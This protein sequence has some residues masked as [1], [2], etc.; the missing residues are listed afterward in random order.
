MAKTDGP[1]TARTR[2]AGGMKKL[3][4]VGIVAGVALGLSACA[5]Q[6]TAVGSWGNAE[7]RTEPSLVLSED[8]RLTG[9]D[10]CNRLVGDYT[11]EGAEITFGMIAS[12]MMFCE[13]VDTWLTGASSAT[14]SGDTMTISD[15]SG[16]E[17][18]TLSRG[19]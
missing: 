7:E 6:P 14:L 15:E 8:G 9:S 19:K 11:A 5:A 3:M 13:G 10:G 18:G 12:T 17:I 4:F 2:Y 16:A 1:G